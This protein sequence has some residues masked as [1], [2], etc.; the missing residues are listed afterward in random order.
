MTAHESPPT[1]E[2]MLAYR[3]WVRGIAR[4]LVADESRVDDVEQ[5]TWLA[6][7][8]SP[9]RKRA[10]VGGWL[11]RVVTSRAIDAHR[12]DSR[13]AARERASARP[14]AEPSAG[15]LV[16]RAEILR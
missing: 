5:A 7:L 15:E 3:A 10:A 12:A 9:P 16:E 13:R 2:A 14:G 6:A 1:I 11:K 4:A 8:E